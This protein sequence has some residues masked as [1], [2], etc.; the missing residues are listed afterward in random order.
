MYLEHVPSLGHVATPG[1]LM[2]RGGELFSTQPET[3]L[4]A[5][6]L[7]L[8]TRGTPVSRYRQWPP[9]PPLGRVRACKWGQ[10][11]YPA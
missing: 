3:S 5:Q 6:R 11:P 9:G 4:L 2:W 1:R 8:V 7:Y 10:N